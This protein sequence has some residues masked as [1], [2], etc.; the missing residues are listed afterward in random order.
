MNAY[1]GPR[2]KENP[3]PLLDQTPDVFQAVAHGW[4]PQ[5]S[6]HLAYV[7]LL[8]LLHLSVLFAALCSEDN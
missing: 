6:I 5:K 3:G 7:V 4:N 1:R 2:F 8:S